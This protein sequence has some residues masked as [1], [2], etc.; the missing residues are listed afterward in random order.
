MKKQLN[1]QE[2]KSELQGSA[3]FHTPLPTS[4]TQATT[5][6]DMATANNVNTKS[7]ND[8]SNERT[9]KPNAQTARS[10]VLNELE[11]GVQEDKRATE[12]YSFEIYSDLIAK[13]EDIQ[14]QY[15]K[16]TGKKLSA[17]RIIRE[18]LEEYLQKA[19]KAL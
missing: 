6:K 15:K 11:E 13:I 9:S 18:A 1:T 3:F 19:E 17:S 4:D 16:K 12:R 5:R 7:S 8:R 2:L 14:Y 10:S